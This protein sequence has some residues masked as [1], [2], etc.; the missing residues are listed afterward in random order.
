M[1]FSSIKVKVFLIITITNAFMLAFMLL[2]FPGKSFALGQDIMKS[3]S[4]YLNTILLG[5]ITTGVESI[6]LDA[7][8]LIKSSLEPLIPKVDKKNPQN[9]N[10]STLSN[11]VIYQKNEQGFNPVY[12]ILK[13]GEKLVIHDFLNDEEN[14]LD[15]IKKT[16]P[17]VDL[18]MKALSIE[19]TKII[20]NTPIDTGEGEDLE[21]IGFMH[22]EF[23]KDK[24]ITS[25]E[26]L[27]KTSIII[28]L[29]IILLSIIF[30]AVI[31][32]LS[33]LKPIEK[34]VSLLKNIA[35]GE[36]DLTARLEL[37]TKSEIGELAQWFNI[38]I[39]KVHSI[40]KDI[41]GS[42][43]NLSNTL[44]Q[45]TQNTSLISGQIKGIND[46]S[47]NVSNL[48]QNLSSNF[49]EISTSS[50]TM[51]DNARSVSEF[52]ESTSSNINS[53][54][55]A[56]EESQTNISMIAS[57]S[58]QMN[59]V[60][61]D[62]QSNT[63]TG[64]EISNQA[65]A[66]VS[67]ASQKVDDLKTAS[68]EIYNVIELIT[69]IS[70]Q[71]KNLALNATIEAARAGEAGKGFA[72]VA[73]EVKELAKQTNDATESIRAK[74]DAMQG[75]TDVTVSEI[76]KISE[77]ITKLNNIVVAISSAVEDQS[78]SIENNSENTSQ[79]ADGLIEVNN[80]L[81]KVNNQ[82]NDAVQNVNG[83]A[84]ATSQVSSTITTSAENLDEVSTNIHGI[85]SS[86]SESEKGVEDIS[87]SCS[88][89]AKM[90]TELKQLVSQFQ[91]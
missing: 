84:S 77:T 34:A 39:E 67:N 72:V 74:I 59:V 76:T 38:F 46:K 26:E 13:K 4:E 25:S 41:K 15:K 69:E 54:A 85:Q 51:A 42:A 90:S 30:G 63:S 31:A 9:E 7:G 60:I 23:S 8:E 80:N 78:R 75:S 21:N 61:N 68:Q 37:K 73:N 81:S 33:I 35:E 55:A 24:L 79:A 89:M 40:V 50:N 49:T 17:K 11:V 44:E 65:V 14:K 66:Y 58:Q 18:K 19:K 20:F 47:S 52:I 3:D 1:N 64:Q 62:I 56:I 48:S 22:V 28:G 86:L 6:D 45:V 2:Y 10:S 32:H 16:I 83:V 91:V 5:N 29:A 57:D 36:G 70:E 53:V 88:D 12:A 43:D 87:K 71:T 82:M 27:K